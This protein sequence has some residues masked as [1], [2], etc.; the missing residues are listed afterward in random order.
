MWIE[1][2]CSYCNNNIL[3]NISSSNNNH[4]CFFCYHDKKLLISPPPSPQL[5]M[6]EFYNNYPLIR[7]PSPQMQEFLYSHPQIQEF[8][9]CQTI[10]TP[11]HF[12]QY[13]DIFYDY[14]L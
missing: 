2:K 4:I 5:Q 3:I 12:Q 11:S 7:T 14:P 6:Q 13:Q 8:F 1:S 9:D 10:R